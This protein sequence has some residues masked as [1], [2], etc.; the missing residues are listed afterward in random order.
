MICHS[1]ASIIG[2]AVTAAHADRPIWDHYRPHSHGKERER[3]SI[4][5]SVYTQFRRRRPW[6]NDEK[7]KK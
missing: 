1:Y 6:S 4:Q 2:F 7:T 5:T 3:G